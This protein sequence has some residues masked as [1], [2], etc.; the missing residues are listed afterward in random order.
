MSQV[1]IT[2]KDDPSLFGWVEAYDQNSQRYYYF[3]PQTK[4]TSWIH[5]SQRPENQPYQQQYQQQPYQQPYPQQQYQQQY[6]QPYQGQYYDPNQGQ[7]YDPNQQYQ[8]QQQQQQQPQKPKLEELCVLWGSLEKLGEVWKNWNARYFVL[9]KTG[10]LEYYKGVS[11]PKDPTL[12]GDLSK[13][14][15]KGSIKVSVCR[16]R[17][18]KGIKA[19]PYCIEIELVDRD[20]LVSFKSEKEMLL[21]KDAFTKVGAEYYDII[22]TDT[23]AKTIWEIKEQEKKKKQAVVKRTNSQLNNKK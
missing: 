11:K 10:D 18:A 13:G 14:V 3:H 21:W 5:P 22:V 8:Q 1:Q 7:Y 23:N 9:K 16:F 6:Q 15:L 12:V 4:E 19:H 17:V 20:F 2:K